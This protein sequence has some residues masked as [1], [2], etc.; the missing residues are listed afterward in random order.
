MQGILEIIVYKE[1]KEKCTAVLTAAFNVKHCD[2][3]RAPHNHCIPRERER[4]ETCTA[5]ETVAS[6]TYLVRKHAL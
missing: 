1:S 2:K 6:Y 5:M 3:D 4:E